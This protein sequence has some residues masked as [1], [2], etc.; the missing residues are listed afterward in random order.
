MRRLE[1]RH[2]H[3]QAG[4]HPTEDRRLH[5]KVQA[6]RA[7]E[8]Q[9]FLQM[10]QEAHRTMTEARQAAI[11]AVHRLQPVH[12]ATAPAAPEDT[13]EAVQADTAEE[14]AAAVPHQEEEDRINH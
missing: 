8:Q 3:L 13:A 12:Q 1:A 5:L 6:S 9:T 14:A 11:T 4:G 2:L 7:E 10:H